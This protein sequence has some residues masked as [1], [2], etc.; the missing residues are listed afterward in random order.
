MS[1][2]LADTSIW[3]WAN[4]GARPDIAEKLAARLER[5]E[6]ATCLPVALEVMHRTDRGERY[7]E[8]FESLFSPV[9]WLELDARTSRRALEM[10]RGLAQVAHGNHRRPA[11]D[12]LI[13]AASELAGDDVV[14][15]FFD[16]DFR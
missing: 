16:R 3:A 11:V 7:E 2:Y 9:H 8:M 12:Y 14:M 6:I 5:D 10:Q 1:R 4:Q 15:W 13:A